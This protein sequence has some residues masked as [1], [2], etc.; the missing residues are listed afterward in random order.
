MTV[1][2]ATRDGGAEQMLWDLLGAVDRERVLLEPVFLESGPVVQD[3]R[4]LRLPVHEVPVGHLRQPFV[5][6]SGVLRLAGLMRR[7]RPDLLLHWMSKAQIYGATA[8][9]AA[10]L[11]QRSLWWQHAVTRGQAMD[12]LATALPARAIVTSSIAAA[13]AQEGLSTRRRIFTIYP[14]AREAVDAKTLRTALGFSP[15]AT[16]IVTVARLQAWKGQHHIIRAVRELLDSGMDVVAVL[17]GGTVFGAS[18]VYENDL[19]RLAADLDVAQRVHFTGQVE[20]ARPYVAAS[21]IFVSASD[22]EPCGIALVEAMAAG[23]PI[24]AVNAGGPAEILQNGLTGVLIDAPSGCAIASAVASLARDS[25]HAAALGQC[26]HVAYEQRFTI[27]R[28][29][30]TFVERMESIATSVKR[31]GAVA[32]T[33]L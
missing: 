18:A 31:G 15:H 28:M 19:R 27:A 17:V 2:W 11:S 21:D 9:I 26:A 33:R 20:D 3:V 10:G 1:P 13:S 4:D 16:M 25:V 6:G 14:G 22:F 8:A 32:T 5:A 12:R 30:E 7:R 24:V 29:A 23:K